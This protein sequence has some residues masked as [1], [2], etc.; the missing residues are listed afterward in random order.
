MAGSLGR[1]QSKCNGKWGPVLVLSKG[2]TL[3]GLHF[4]MIS[5]AALA[6]CTSS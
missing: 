3:A 2:E 5:Q 1:S 6:V 4:K